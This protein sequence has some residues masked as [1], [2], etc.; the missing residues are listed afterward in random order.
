MAQDPNL[1]NFKLMRMAYLKSNVFDI[2]KRDNKELD[3]E[4]EVSQ[5]TSAKV[6]NFLNEIS[7]K[8]ANIWVEAYSK[9]TGQ[10]AENSR[11]FDFF[12][13][14][15]EFE[16][17]I[18]IAKMMKGAP[19]AE[20]AERL[21]IEFGT[22]NPIA[23]DTLIYFIAD[24][25]ISS[26]FQINCNGIDPHHAAEVIPDRIRDAHTAE[27]LKQMRAQYHAL[28][29]GITFAPVDEQEEKPIEEAKPDIPITDFGIP[30]IML[31]DFADLNADKLMDYYSAVDF[32]GENVI[33]FG[34]DGEEI[35]VDNPDPK[36]LKAA[37][38]KDLWKF[39]CYSQE[40]NASEERMAEIAKTIDNAESRT[41]V[42]TV[43][44]MLAH[45]ENNNFDAI[46]RRIAQ[47]NVI[48]SEVAMHRAFDFLVAMAQT[49]DLDIDFHG[50]KSKQDYI[51]MVLDKQPAM[52]RESP[53]NH[54]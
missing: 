26:M 9:A 23:T 5:E 50:V 22:E 37:I 12:I 52:E 48:Q 3:N 39:A 31:E 6:D 8:F 11:A 15:E 17:G 51:N 1:I 34:P 18:N 40:M 30:Q 41:I 14:Q 27:E 54:Q 36:L 35:I 20:L 29:A 53:T 38:I 2:P 19:L 4:S 46:L 43:C 47:S 28:E 32:D 7:L 42:N 45:E 10:S 13:T 44:H 49:G 33:I 24:E 21:T 25:R 16:R